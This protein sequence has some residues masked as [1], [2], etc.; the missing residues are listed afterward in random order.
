[1]KICFPNV[2]HEVVDF[3]NSLTKSALAV[4]IVGKVKPE[5]FAKALFDEDAILNYREEILKNALPLALKKAK[6]E[7]KK[8]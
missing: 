3:V 6:E 7:A 1:M 2:S 5:D 8:V 4:A